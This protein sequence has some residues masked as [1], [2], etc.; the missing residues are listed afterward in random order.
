MKYPGGKGGVYQRL[1]NLIPPHEVYIETHLGG[2][3]VMRNKRPA[4][5]NI[6]IE[7]NPKVIQMWKNYNRVDIELI[8][9]DAVTYLKSYKFTGNELIYCD[10]PYLRE[11]RKKHKP[12]Y[13][14]EYTDKQHIELLKVIKSLPCMV[15]ISGYKSP[16]YA[17]LLEYWNTYSFEAAC[18]HG[19]A[20]EY[21][22]MNYP[23]PVELHDY[24][25]LGD[26][27]RE[28]ERLKKISENLVRRFRSM[29]VLER[30]ALLA[31]I[32]SSC[33]PESTCTVEKQTGIFFNNL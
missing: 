24:R 2:G 17:D 16:F 14:Y 19:T 20:T 33:V 13:K 3:A 12:L 11:T 8:Q 9:A 22:W 15:M 27:F 1:I 21:I 6:G 28:R 7:I 5:H 26:T 31:A 18:H 29:P 4:M 25:Y 32:N 30:R 10:P 23:A